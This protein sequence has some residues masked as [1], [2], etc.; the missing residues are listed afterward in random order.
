[1][2]PSAPKMP[3][4]PPP[5][6]VPTIDQA[7]EQQQKNDNANMRRGR[8]ADILTGPLGDTSAPSVGTKTLLGQ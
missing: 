3:P 5:P 8:A 1:M 7:R 6:I 4:P 2:S